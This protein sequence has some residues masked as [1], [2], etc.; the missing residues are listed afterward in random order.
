MGMQARCTLEKEPYTRL[1]SAERAL[2]DQARIQWITILVEN[3][4]LC[5]CLIWILL[6]QDTFPKETAT[7]YAIP[8]VGQTIPEEDEVEGPTSPVGAFRGVPS[9]PVAS[10]GPSTNA[11]AAEFAQRLARLRTLQQVGNQLT[12]SMDLC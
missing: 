3:P 5:F 10:K 2:V 1:F 12:A 4:K 7:A 6:L 8:N 9:P 11:K